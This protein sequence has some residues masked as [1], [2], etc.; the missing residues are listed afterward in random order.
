MIKVGSR[1]CF[2]FYYQ[3]LL[4]SSMPVHKDPDVYFKILMKKMD[5][6]LIHKMRKHNWKIKDLIKY[7]IDG[8]NIYYK[9]KINKLRLTRNDHKKFCACMLL[10]VRLEIVER[11]EHILYFPKKKPKKIK[12]ENRY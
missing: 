6:F 7:C 11:E 9:R 3:N 12:F 1:G 8:V 4:V 2:C 10:L 5:N